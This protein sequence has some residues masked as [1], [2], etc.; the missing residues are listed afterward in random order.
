[1]SDTYTYTTYANRRSRAGSTPP[2]GANGSMRHNGPA[3]DSRSKIT[4]DS[5]S[6]SLAGDES[7]SVVAIVVTGPGVSEDGSTKL[8]TGNVTFAMDAMEMSQLMPASNNN[9]L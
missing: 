3:P 5:K 4:F 2:P 8:F 7:K 9:V 6:Y 1:M